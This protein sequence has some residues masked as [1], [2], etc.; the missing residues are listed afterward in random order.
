MTTQMMFDPKIS[1][2]SISRILSTEVQPGMRIRSGATGWEYRVLDI[3]SNS[4]AK[5]QRITGKDAGREI[6]FHLAGMA[7]DGITL[8]HEGR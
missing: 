2:D 1:D 6:T 7:R 5:L 4:Y 3:E 8:I